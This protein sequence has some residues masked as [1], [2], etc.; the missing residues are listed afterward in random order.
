MSWTITQRRADSTVVTTTTGMTL[1][2]LR[3]PRGARGEDATWVSLT[4]AE[5]DALTPDPATLYIVVPE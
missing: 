5:Y 1:D 2:Q 3:G 4:Q